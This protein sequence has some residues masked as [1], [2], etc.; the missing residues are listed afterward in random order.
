[1]QYNFSKLLNLNSLAVQDFIE[2]HTLNIGAYDDM[3][4]T[5][6]TNYYTKIFNIF[7]TSFKKEE[8]QELFLEL[9][10]HKIYQGVPYAVISTEIYSLK[11]LLLTEVSD[12]DTNTNTD[13]IKFL[14]L[15][16]SIND[17]IAH[18]YLLKYIDNLLSLNKLRLNSLNDLV[19]KDLIV[20]YEAHLIWLTNLAQHIKTKNKNAF[21]VLD[22]KMCEFGIWLNNAEKDIIQNSLT[23]TRMQDM[24]KNLHLYATR[25][26]N[27][28]GLDAHHVAITYLEKA[29][30]L[31]L[32][33]GTELSLLDN[34]VINKKISKDSLTGALNRQALQ[35][36]F[37][38]QYELAL[39]TNNP[40]VLAMCD[41]D[42]FKH[43]ND[44]YG[45]IAGDHILKLFVDIVKKNTRKSDIILRYGGE[46]FIIILPAMT[47]DKGY[48]VLEK[49]RIVLEQSVLEFNKQS[50]HI[51]IS[52]GAMEI[53]P[54]H[55]Y[56]KNFLDKYIT[57]IDKKLYEAKEN[58]RNRLEMN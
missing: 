36:I 51:T 14:N 50:I 22:E 42:F 39:A 40:F 33:I 20:Y 7:K 21:P 57:V 24:H 54:E 15:F 28:I 43:V 6:C 9:A 32:S 3:V 31:S 35:N 27:I 12:T 44:T 30:F 52:I 55:L 16:R 18:L 26:Y 48:A 46:E 34:I 1:L 2:N 11:N 5:T 23:Y 25:I 8:L 49:I 58:G 38:N 37:Q 45:H 41:L 19:E 53:Q 4:G 10:E 56:K 47:K 13:V 29:E 17:S